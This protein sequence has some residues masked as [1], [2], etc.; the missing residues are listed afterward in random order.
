M[1]KLLQMFLALGELTG[2]LRAVWRALQTLPADEK[3]QLAQEMKQAFE[4]LP[5]AKTDE[6]KQDV[7]ASLS[8]LIHRL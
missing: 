2:L 1:A 5:E 6:E 7:A 8:A 3:R 4:R